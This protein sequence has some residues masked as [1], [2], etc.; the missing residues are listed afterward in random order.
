MSL[1]IRSRPAGRHC[2]RSE[3]IQKA[4]KES[5]DC[6]VAYAPRND[7]QILVARKLFAMTA[8]EYWIIRFRG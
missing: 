3:A 4:A 6:F 7:D 8:A 1:V 5:L 2:E